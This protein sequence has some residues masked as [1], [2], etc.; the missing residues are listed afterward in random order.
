LIW[1]TAGDIFVI[2]HSIAILFLFTVL[3]RIHGGVMRTSLNDAATSRSTAAWALS[4]IYLASAMRSA[5]AV[6]IYTIQNVGLAGPNYSQI[7]NGS[8]VSS[9]QVLQLNNDGHVLGE[10][11]QFNSSGN[12]LGPN[13]WLFNGASTQLLGL[14]GP[15]YSYST[16]G[17][18][19][20]GSTAAA[21]NDSGQVA[22]SSARFDSSGNSLGQDAWIYS[23]ATTTQLGYTGVG[24]NYA[25]PGGT[26][27]NSGAS[28]INDGGQVIGFSNRY[29]STG[30]DL[31]SDLWLVSGLTTLQVGLTGANYE[32]IASGG[33]VE[34]S[35]YSDVPSLNSRGQTFGESERFSPTGIT[36][37]QDSWCF[38][39]NIT[40][41]IGLVGPDYDELIT[42]GTFHSSQAMQ[43][44]DNGQVIGNSQRFGTTG[45]GDDAWL[46]NGSSTQQI[47][48]TGANY[49]Y[50]VNNKI[51]P[52]G[53]TQIYQASFVGEL[54]NAG[55]VVGTS[56]R[57]DASGNFMGVDSWFYDGK[58]T[59]QIGLIG[60]N[61]SYA[62]L[63]GDT[64]EQSTPTQINIAGQVVG[65]S[66]RYDSSR[67]NLG[68]DAWFFN[69]STTQGIGLTGPATDGSYVS[70]QPIQLNNFGQVIGT[71]A[72]GASGRTIAFED[73]WLFDSNTDSTFLLQFSVSSTGQSDTS[74]ELLT[75]GGVVLGW[76]TLY[77]GADIEGND[78]FYWSETEG[79]HDLGTLIDGGLTAQ[80][81]QYLAD[82]YGSRIPGAAGMTADGSPQY[83]L[84]DGQLIGQTGA[85]SLF[86]LAA[87]VPEPAVSAPLALGILL[88]VRR[89]QPAS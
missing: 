32:Y 65:T 66:N 75:D 48:L 43:L 55:Q 24:Y 21:L 52:P 8:T 53:P 78:A 13:A 27:R 1:V 35:S 61:Y 29:S 80:G 54:N 28:Q 56:V 84:G 77:D 88:L 79:F 34:N 31:G 30:A 20:Q 57:D 19:I 12:R 85:S 62:S 59:R 23:G 11:E 16:S 9:I 36:L 6:P 76:Y 70:S 51:T 63:P 89:R 38:N 67:T 71:S 58:T 83:I 14:T 46:F 17:E 39:G 49:S 74:P 3:K 73:A 64:F 40:Q 50:N 72:R 81:W 45:G 86:L 41:Q 15:A 42:G 47:G 2:V 10:S 18:T 60:T 37:G 69:G 5:Q 7:V 22:G 26:Y 44:N 33:T 25:A 82:V 87:N 68:Q 4:L